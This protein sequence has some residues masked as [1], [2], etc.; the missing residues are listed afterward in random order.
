MNT[1]PNLWLHHHVA[2]SAF[3]DRYPYYSF[4]LAQ[5]TAVEDPTVDVM[6]VCTYREKIYLRV[7]VDFFVRQLQYLNGVLLH[8][9]HHVV[10][11]HLT[12]PKFHD[13]VHPDLIGLAMEISANEYISEPL[14]GQPAKWQDY[15]RFGI[16]SGQSTLQRYELLVRARRNSDRLPRF[17]PIDRHI[18]GGVL[19]G[20]S[21]DPA[22]TPSPPQLVTDLVSAVIQ[23]VQAQIKVHGPLRGPMLLAGKAPGDLLEELSGTH[24][25]PPSHR[26]WKAAIRM[27]VGLIR[28]PVH[29]FARPNRRFPDKLGQVPGRVYF[30]GQ[31]DMPRL[32]VAIDTSASMSSQELCE[33]AR[34]L[35]PLS[36]L[37][38]ITVVECDAAIQRVYPF[39]GRLAGVAGRGGT[40][41]RPVFAAEFLREHR[42]DGIIY[43]TDG[44]GPYPNEE[45]RVKT[46]WV[47]S[48]PD[49]FTCPWGKQ[50][51]L[52]RFQKSGLA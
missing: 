37:V 44:W 2:N 28:A 25:R 3:L 22:K 34:Q 29:T 9:V 51:Q 32:I 30:P 21:D 47:L 14:P 40:D 27:F 33:I 31:V 5:M 19:G 6:A 18:T 8:E 16:Q 43:F 36:S 46:L 4:I 41:L 42:P 26:E 50:A 39:T 20:H 1:D 49:Q 52:S 17:L 13:A 23:Q 7:N 12:D 11:G 10:L 38:K 35:I 45:P 24:D 15:T 48:K